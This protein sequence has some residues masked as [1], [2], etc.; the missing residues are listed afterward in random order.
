MKTGLTCLAFALSLSEPAL[1][2][3]GASDANLRLDGTIAPGGACEMTLGNGIIDFGR[4]SVSDLNPNPSK[5]TDLEKKRVKMRIDCDR[6]RRYALVAKSATSVVG[7]DLDFGLS[8][9]SDHSITGSLYIR[10]DSASAHIEGARGYYTAA[11]AAVDLA[12]AQWGPSTFSVMPVPNGS[13]ALGFVTSDGSYATPPPIANFD[14]YLLV[15]PRIRP[16]NELD[17]SDE[18]TFSGSLGFEIT[19]F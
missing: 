17:L 6:P 14:T 9:Q 5:P 19:Y 4:M 16:V 15:S 12:T 7:D 3:V 1:A 10:F 13:F 11:D 18:I 8:S 2:S